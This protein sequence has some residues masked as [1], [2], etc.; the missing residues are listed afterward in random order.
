MN[1]VIP[2]HA[3]VFQIHLHKQAISL[4]VCVCMHV[5]A[6]V[7]ACMSKCIGKLRFT[8][9]NLVYPRWDKTKHVLENVV[10]HASNPLKTYQFQ[11]TTKLRRVNLRVKNVM[12]VIIRPRKDKQSVLNVLKTIFVL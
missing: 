3:Q 8:S 7:C 11:V 4:G 6:C 1:L 2:A 5:C 12:M 10:V 9:N